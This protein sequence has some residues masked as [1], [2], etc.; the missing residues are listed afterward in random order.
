MD[1]PAQNPLPVILCQDEALLAIDKPAGLLSLPDGYDPQAPHVLGVLTPTYGRLWIVHRLD[2]GTSG[3]MILARS[4]EAHRALNT[5]FETRQTSKIYH[6]L[7]NGSPEW[8]EKVVDLPLLPD[9][10]RMH[11]TIVD[12]QRGK[13]SV[14]RLKVLE[15]YGAYTLVRAEPET[16]RAHQVRVHLASQGYPVVCDPLYGDGKGIYLSQI[17]PGYRRGKEAGTESPLLGRL[18]LHAWSLTFLHPI[19]GEKVTFQAPYPRDISNTLRLLTKYMSQS[20][21]S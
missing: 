20:P 10:D 14:T 9:G 21:E 5:Q 18:G 7:A 4:A 11:R 8:E 1:S 19:S 3:V 15:H 16:G 17:K 12:G 6:A 2:K 13:P